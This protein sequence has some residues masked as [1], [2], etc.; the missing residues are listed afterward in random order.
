[1]KLQAVNRPTDSSTV[2]DRADEERF[3]A[4]TAGAPETFA[5]NLATALE[6]C[7]QPGTTLVRLERFLD[8]VDDRSAE[9]E[10]MAGELRYCR[11]LLRVLDQS[12]Y[13]TDVVVRHSEFVPWLKN[14]DLG[15]TVSAADITAEAMVLADAQSG[16]KHKWDALRV[17]NQRETL[18]IATRDV[19]AHEDVLSV[20]EDLANLADAMME[21]AY[22]IAYAETTRR[23][24]TPR[25]QDGPSGEGESAFTIIGMGKLGGRELNFSS[26]IDLLFIYS[27]EGET[28]GGDMRAVSNTE[29]FNKLGELVI[30]G[31]TEDTAEGYIHRV[32]MRLRPHGISGPLAVSLE[33][34]F[35]YYERY[36]QAWERQAL[37]KARCCAG[38]TAT[39]ETFI[40]GTRHFAY[41]RYFDDATLED[42]RSMKQQ[43]EQQVA[44]RGET[45]LEVKLGRGGIRDIE[46]TVQVLQLLNGGRKPEVRTARTLDAIE[47]LADTGGLSPLEANTLKRH[48]RFLREVE[49]RLQIE[50]NRQVHALPSKRDKLDLFA[51]KLGY[52]SA[53][54]FM[55]TYR[56]RAE[57]T[58]SVLER[59]L[60]TKGAGNLWIDDLLNPFSDGAEGLERLAE[61]YHFADAKAAREELLRLCNGTA[62]RPHSAHTRQQ[63]AAAA[64]S[65]LD[66]LTDTA[67]PNR[68]LSRMANVLMNLKA[69]RSIYE[70]LKDNPHFSQY[71]VKLSENSEY[72]TNIL[73]RD[74]SLFDMLGYAGAL[75]EPTSQDELEE[76]LAMLRGAVQPEAALY[77]LRDGETLRVGM[78]DLFVGISVF[79]VGAELSRL[80]EICVRECLKAARARTV[81]RYGE[82]GHGFAIL[83]LGKSG[84]RELGYGSDL[85]IV[86]VYESKPDG[87]SSMD[88]AQYFTDLAQRTIKGLSERTKFGILYEMDA[89]LRPD[90]SKGA[91][92][93]SSRRF[94]EYYENEADSWERLALVKARFIA[95][96]ESFGRA[97][98]SVAQDLAFG[99]PLTRA[100]LDR[101]E[102]IRRRVAE[103]AGPLDLKKQ[104]GGVAEIE[105]TV[106]LLQMRYGKQI[107]AVKR[108]DFQGAVE[109][110]QRGGALTSRQK[111]VLMDA[112]T[113]FRRIENRIRMMHGT[114]GSSLPESQESRRDLANRLGIEADLL[115]QVQA[116]R[117]K[118][119]ALYQDILGRLT[120]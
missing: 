49:H 102:D 79:D 82:L 15:H 69:P 84:G 4:L 72:L 36:G 3:G 54:G 37:I 35:D 77:R 61:E 5:K 19:F 120:G 58:R 107:P 59:F 50:G 62:E 26:D 74:P 109:A 14:T 1:M 16:L 105:F 116:H 100:N 78:R 90:G 6:E 103:Q 29:F 115:E 98:E 47:R 38:D 25:T 110:L 39:G 111:D 7:A 60:A 57:E 48:Y 113:F 12:R 13:L 95:G 21:C 53:E 70:I 23:Y 8:E 93:V 76:Q 43:M 71:I 104:Q 32:D 34:A 65:I 83:G 22:R 10:N 20:A 33:H 51:R 118:V 66:A 91:L 27:D 46:F 114:P 85:D 24:G 55:N 41:P 97:M 44:S 2:T 30:K 67:D 9:I 42:V 80:S 63:F 45:E 96:D 92:V 73:T 17:I 28:T 11:M 117:D 119:H 89:R 64:P 40:E 106:R 99:M 87:A 86:F 68:A 18:R 31:L 112:Y 101:I 108:G 94:P 56:S 75:Q 81:D 88:P 52:D